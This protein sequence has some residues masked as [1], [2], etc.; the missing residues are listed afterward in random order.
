[1]IARDA[2]PA[3]AAAT[4]GSRVVLQLADGRE[5]DV[6]TIEHFAGIVVV[7]P[8]DPV[9]DE[10]PDPDD[11]LEAFREVL[12]AWEGVTPDDLRELLEADDMPPISDNEQGMLEFLVDQKI[13]DVDELRGRLALLPEPPPKPVVVPPLPTCTICGKPTPSRDRICTT[14]DEIPF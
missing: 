4:P 9:S 1:M 5:I 13:S 11:S 12:E 7:T 2:W 10:I 8:A 14:C 3:L 6:S